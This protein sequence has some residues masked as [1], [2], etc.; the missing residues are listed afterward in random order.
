[1]KSILSLLLT[2]MLVACLDAPQ[3]D[4]SDLCGDPPPIVGIATFL[5]EI[6]DQ[7]YV[8]AT[9]DSDH[10]RALEVSLTRQWEQCM[11]EARTTHGLATSL[12]AAR[13]KRNVAKEAA[14]SGTRAL[15]WEAYA[16]AEAA[17]EDT[18]AR[19]DRWLSNGHVTPLEQ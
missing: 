3:A 14:L 10:Q 1:M 18:V 4:I 16:R 2:F 8:C 9:A 15:E 12:I 6:R 19:L 17:W 5:T 13:R 7:P 11:T